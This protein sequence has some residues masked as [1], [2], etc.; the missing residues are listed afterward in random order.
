M[1][2]LWLIYKEILEATVCI[3][4]GILHVHSEFQRVLGKAALGRQPV[5][6]VAI[7]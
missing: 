3:S 4:Q 6:Y 2:F 1:E 5:N 7:Q